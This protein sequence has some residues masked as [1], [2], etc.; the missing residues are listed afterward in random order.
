MENYF[1]INANIKRAE[2]NALTAEER[3]SV[4]EYTKRIIE[5][6]KP[7]VWVDPLERKTT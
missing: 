4:R 2:Q 6:R 1:W 3:E 5:A 7:G